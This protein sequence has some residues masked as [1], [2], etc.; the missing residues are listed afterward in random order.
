MIFEEY[1]SYIL[2][3]E[4]S[5]EEFT[6]PGSNVILDKS[7]LLSNMRK[8]LRDNGDKVF[9]Y[10]SLLVN[11][12]LCYVSKDYLGKN[13]KFD[14]N[15]DAI[16]ENIRTRVERIS[17]LNKKMDR[18]IPFSY[19][20]VFEILVYYLRIATNVLN[21]EKEQIVHYVTAEISPEAV[22]YNLNHKL[23]MDILD[24]EW[25]KKRWKAFYK[26]IKL[27]YAVKAENYLKFLLLATYIR[28]CEIMGN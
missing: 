17:T 28:Y 12:L 10:D 26:E 15:M 23:T 2:S 7:E 22:I 25:E 3:R 24:A 14:E 11:T 19:E 20:R 13:K 21:N 1:C 6:I 5:L 18:P 4:Q 27:S 9:D 16:L 8:V